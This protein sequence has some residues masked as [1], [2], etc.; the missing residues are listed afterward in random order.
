[1]KKK[2]ANISI[3]RLIATIC[4]LQFHVFFILYN[5]DIPYE[6]LLS[7]GVQGLTFLSGL[8]YSQKVI[9]DNKGFYINNFKKLI[10]P[11]LIIFLLMCLWNLVYMFIFRSWNYVALFFGHRAYNNGLLFQP[12]NYYYILYIYLCYLVTPI[13]QRNDRYSLLVILGAILVEVTIGFFFGCSIIGCFYIIGYYLG[14]R[15]FSQVTNT[16]EKFSWKWFLLFLLVLLVTLGGYILIVMNP[17]SGSY[18]VVHLYSLLQ[19]ILSATFGAA[20]CLVIIHALRWINKFNTPKFLLFTD[21]ITLN[22]YLFNQAFMCGAMNVAVWADEMWLKTLLV[23][24]FTIGFSI[25]AY[26]IYRLTTKQQT[27]LQQ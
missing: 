13:L 3:Y 1:M 20:T 2:F 11:G 24:I 4:I 27:T 10:I 16:E 15:L 21:K 7:K 9:T 6:T 17:I 18:F 19:N 5:K 26:F 25:I 8:L 14:K 22:I 12:A 23:Y